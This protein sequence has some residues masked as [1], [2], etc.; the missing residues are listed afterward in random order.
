MQGPF[1]LPF[2]AMPSTEDR[3]LPTPP[4]VR[5]VQDAAERGDLEEPVPRLLNLGLLA[6]VTGEL[7]VFGPLMTRRAGGVLLGLVVAGSA[8]AAVA[9][10]LG[11][12]APELEE[13]ADAALGEP[14]DD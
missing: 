11:L 3:K 12:A 14:D 6:Q 2:A 9:V 10:V 7:L 1:P 4:R 13:L 5:L 8:V